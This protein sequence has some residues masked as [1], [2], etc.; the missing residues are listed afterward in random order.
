MQASNRLNDW[1]KQ[2]PVELYTLQTAAGFGKFC[3]NL[4]PLYYKESKDENKSDNLHD[5]EQV[6]R[7]SLT[8]IVLNTC[9]TKFYEFAN[10]KYD[11][12]NTL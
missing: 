5:E 6:R 10:L 9:K 4:M 2:L 7:I 8:R 11:N 1:E 12:N 3:T